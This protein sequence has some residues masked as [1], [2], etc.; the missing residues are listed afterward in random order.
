MSK[1]IVSPLEP[2]AAQIEHWLAPKE[3]GGEGLSFVETQE[4]LAAAGCEVS[5][6]EVSHWWEERREARTLAL[7]LEMV[8]AGA[9]H[10]RQLD[11]A[12][13][14]SPPPSLDTLIKLFQTLIL[15]MTAKGAKEPAYAKLAC[16]LSRTCLDFVSYQSDIRFKQ[17]QLALA[18]RKLKLDE[19]KHAASAA[20]PKGA[21]RKL[22]PEEKEAEYKR[23]FGMA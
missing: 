13:A 11:L 19:Q 3:L 16:Q 5:A 4:R 22:T 15:K 8:A 1:K 18:A 21:G 23:I 14:K 6:L 7:V 12:F 9:K 17:Q 10:A 20:A 2:H